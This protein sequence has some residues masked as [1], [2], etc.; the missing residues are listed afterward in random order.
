MSKPVILQVIPQLDTGGAERSTLE[1]VDALHK[2]GATALV[3]TEGGRMADEVG[4]LGGE[5]IHLPVAS[6]NPLTL[7]SNAG[8][9]GELIG[10]R[11]VALVHARS[12]APAW[13]CLLASRR[14]RIPFVTTYHGIYNEREPFK[15]QY[16]SVMARGDLVIA[17]SR[18]TA[19]MV[20]AR[21]RVP[22]QRLRTIY[23]GVDLERFSR[24]AVAAE[25]LT[26]LREAW[27]I[28]AGRP[29]VLHPARL[30]GWKGQSVVIGAA[31]QLHDAD[32]LR[33]AVFIL[34]GDHQDRDDYRSGLLR[35]I[36]AAE[37][38]GIVRLVGHCAD[39]PAAYALARA[40]LIASTEPEAFGRTSAEAQA[41][42]CPVIATDIGA[43]PETVKAVPF[44]DPHETTGWLVPPGDVD[45]LEAALRQVL[46]L[47]DGELAAIGQRAI[48][49]VAANY[50]DATMKGQTLAVYDELLGTRLAERFRRGLRPAG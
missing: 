10:E 27:G 17:N 3:V 48:D 8:R 13:S 15:R 20:E 29:V 41:M 43:P 44:V 25:R 12:R 9:I 1:I 26:A 16:N 46:A 14:K 6:K 47:D 22:R 31:Q 50:S 4:R 33:N 32:A 37:L 5:I 18:F 11:G 19:D 35:Q 30:S 49:N 23:R 28:E 2:A 21:H 24:S 34:A 38:D 45:R 40:V 39:M 36:A 42:G 7:L